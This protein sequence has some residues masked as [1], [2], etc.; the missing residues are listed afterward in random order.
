MNPRVNILFFKTIYYTSF[1]MSLL[2]FLTLWSYL[3]MLGLK[4]W[5][6]P[7]T[8]AV[9][10]IPP[11][12]PVFGRFL[13]VPDAKKAFKSGPWWS[14]IGTDAQ[15]R[16]TWAAVLYGK[17]YPVKSIPTALGAVPAPAG[18]VYPYGMPGGEV[19]G[20]REGG[21]QFFPILI[22]KHSDGTFKAAFPDAPVTVK[23][24]PEREWDS[25]IGTTLA[26]LTEQTPRDVVRSLIGS[27]TRETIGGDFKPSARPCMSPLQDCVDFS[28]KVHVDEYDFTDPSHDFKI[29]YDGN[30]TFKSIDYLNK[31]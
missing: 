6:T 26:T 16:Q 25:K 27:P 12:A 9:Q 31:G 3:A 24:G 22:V 1:F 19:Y 20:V 15:G 30:G 10:G 18:S 4:E 8:T 13:F 7:S 2:F 28:Q 17:V 21:F 14:P 29:S 5:A 11:A 23:V